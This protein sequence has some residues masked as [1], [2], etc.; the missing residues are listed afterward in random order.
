MKKLITGILV[1][2]FLSGGV[3]FSFALVSR[4]VEKG[5]IRL[6]TEERF[7]KIFGAKVSIGKIRLKFL[8]RLAFSDFEF[9]KGYLTP[10]LAITGVEKIVFGYGWN[11]LINRNFKMPKNVL[12]QTPNFSLEA[13]DLSQILYHW[14]F[15]QFAGNVS[16]AVRIDNGSVF[17]AQKATGEKNGLEHLDGIVNKKNA[18]EVYLRFTGDLAGRFK[19]RISWEGKVFPKTKMAD[20][21]V[22][23]NDVQCASSDV[24]I[25]HDLNGMLHIKDSTLIIDELKFSVSSIPFILRG[26]IEGFSGSDPKF[27]LEVKE[28]SKFPGGEMS[29]ALDGD[30]KEGKVWGAFLGFD[31]TFPFRGDFSKNASGLNLTNLKIGNTMEADCEF[32]FADWMTHLKLIRGKERYNVR[33]ALK[34]FRVGMDITADHLQLYDFDVVTSC[35]IDL[36]PKSDP[37]NFGN[38]Q[39]EASLSTDYFVFDYAPLADFKGTFVVS[40]EGIRHVDLSWGKGYNAVGEIIFG[41]PPLVALDIKASKIVLSEVTKFGFHTLPENLTGMMDAKISIRGQAQQPEVS[42][43]ISVDSGSV[44][45]LTYDNL[46]LNFYGNRHYLKLKDSKITR[47]SRAYFVKGDIDFSSKNIFSGVEVISEN[48]LPVW[49]GRN[50]GMEAPGSPSQPVHDKQIAQIERSF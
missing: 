45:N 49:S 17:W 26:R 23:L 31:A 2:A 43:Y 19:G 14:N 37:W 13:F 21:I 9:N 1:I 39:F 11:S 4:S 38:Y 22:R 48:H 27:H 12:L 35:H 40:S 41:K 16:F 36:K 42:G 28:L 3:W 5:E 25:F 33:F 46:L 15:F 8:R 7:G 6:K 20:L 47:R 50:M 44:K 34:N 32:Q 10:G 30:L 18:N 24:S 29:L